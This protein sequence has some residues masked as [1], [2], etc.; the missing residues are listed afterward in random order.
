MARLVKNHRKDGWEYVVNG[1]V[2]GDGEAHLLAQMLHDGGEKYHGQCHHGVF[3]G[4]GVYDLADGHQYK[5]DWM[6]G[7]FN[8]MAVNRWPS[9]ERYEGEWKDVKQHGLG[10]QFFPSGDMFQGEYRTNKRVYGVYTFA[11]GDKELRKFDDAGNEIASKTIK[12]L[13]VWCVIRAGHAPI[14]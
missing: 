4:S 12:G 7:K 9:G 2:D 8:G 11:N 6:G 1:S 14:R 13:D 3:Q 10:V 5:G